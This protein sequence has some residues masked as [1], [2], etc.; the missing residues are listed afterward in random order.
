MG[1]GQRGAATASALAAAGVSESAAHGLVELGEPLE[2]IF[3]HVRHTMHV[4]HGRAEGRAEGG[5]GAA[6][7]ATSID[8][9]A[10]G[11]EWTRTGRSYCWMDTARMSEVGVTAGVLKV[12]AA[13]D[14][15]TGGAKAKA[16][17]KGKRA[18]AASAATDKKQPKLSSFFTPKN[19]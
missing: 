12:I 10:V 3:S 13:V 15:A 7:A 16:P 18:A 9:M 14:G 4:E 17:P 19:T 5:Q 6:G 11:A 2:H 1:G 8:S